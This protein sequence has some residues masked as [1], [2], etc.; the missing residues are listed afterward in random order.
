M[1]HP[2]YFAT[3]GAGRFTAPAG[4]YGVLYVGADERTA[5]IEAFGRR[6]TTGRLLGQNFVTRSELAERP[7]ALVATSRPL[8]VVDLT[9]AGLARIGADNR[10]SDGSYTTSRRWALAFYQH[11]SQPDGI[12]YRSRH[13]PSR[14]VIAIFD[15]AAS[16]VSANPLGSLA[17]PVNAWLLAE[18]LETYGFDLLS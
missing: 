10:L 11:P 4:E 3:S 8:T 18:I 13:D 16:A 5:F 12:R 17:D 1:Y 2:I 6:E 9:G 7:R 14:H 15:R